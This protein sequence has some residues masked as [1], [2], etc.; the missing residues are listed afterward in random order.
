MDFGIII[1]NIPLL[2]EGLVVTL[3]LIGTSM[4]IGFIFSLPL[5][6]IRNLK[7]PVLNQIVWSFTYFFRSTPLLLQL[8]LIYFG[9]SQFDFI[10]ESFLWE[11]FREPYFCGLLAYSLNTSAYTAEILRGSMENMSRHEVEAAEAFGLSKFHCYTRIIIPNSLRRALP[12]YSNE[13]I[14]LL[15]SSSV[16]S[17]VTIVELTGAASSLYNKYYDPFTPYITVA[18]IYIVLV[19]IISFAFKLLEKKF[20]A[21]LANRGAGLTQRVKVGNPI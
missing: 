18:G 20:M 1:D 7:I 8:Y 11:F 14:F 21:H 10:R 13:V 5:A 6:I 3:K 17:V 9:T 12:P 15:H 16:A 4:V 19:L 2:L